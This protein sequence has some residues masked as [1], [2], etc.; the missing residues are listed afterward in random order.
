[1]QGEQSA[2]PALARP[3][4]ACIPQRSGLLSNRRG[5]RRPLPAAVEAR[6]RPTDTHLIPDGVCASERCG[7]QGPGAAVHG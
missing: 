7:R 2:A 4:P 5:C 3:P 1:M 6:F